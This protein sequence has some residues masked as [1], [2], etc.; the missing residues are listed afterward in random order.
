MN[1]SRNHPA[2][3]AYERTQLERVEQQLQ[4]LE[5][6]PAWVDFVGAGIIALLA[7]FT[8]LFII[9]QAVVFFS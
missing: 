3:K 4:E 6:Q 8:V 7:L 1:P 2:Y 9:G 5:P